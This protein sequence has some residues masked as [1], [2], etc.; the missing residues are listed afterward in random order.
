MPV[1]PSQASGAGTRGVDD[2]DCWDTR[3]MPD[4]SRFRARLVAVVPTLAAVA[5]IALTV[6]LGRWQLTRAAQ[7][8]AQ[9]RVH[10]SDAPAV[11]IDATTRDAVPPAGS[12]VLVR[13]AFLPATTVLLDNRTRQGIAGFHVLTAFQPEA[14]GPAVVVLRG[15]IARDLRDRTRLPPVITPAG[16]LELEGRVQA[17]LEQP[18]LLGEDP[19]PGPELRIWQRWTPQRF[20]RWSA[21]RI[22]PWLLRQT[23][24]EPDGLERDWVP[25]GSGADK[26]RAYAAQW[27]SMAAV[28]AGLWLWF[29]P[30]RAWRRPRTQRSA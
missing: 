30:V 27:F 16:V 24:G 9:A 1:G 18:M 21:V 29:V 6:S 10:A 7:K 11:R 13:G 12:R 28:V 15:W 19:E 8:D 26:H 4:A 23:A 25:A 3:A 14:G 20:E 22:A 17:T 5:V 2:L